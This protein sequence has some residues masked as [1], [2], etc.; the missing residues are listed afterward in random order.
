M[1]VKKIL[2]SSEAEAEKQKTKIASEVN[3]QMQSLEKRI[4]DKRSKS[5]YEKSKNV[6][7]SV[8]NNFDD[9]KMKILAWLP[10]VP[11]FARKRQAIIKLW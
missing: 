7:L 8:K 4:E 5:K 11:N 1:E 2:E 10:G 9:P 3:R 6:S